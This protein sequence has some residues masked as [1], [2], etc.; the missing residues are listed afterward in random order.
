M[1]KICKINGFDGPYS[2][3]SNFHLCMVT[4]GG[5]TYA[6]VEHAYQAAKARNFEDHDYVAAAIKP[7]EAKRRGREIP[8]RDDWEKIKLDVMYELLK[9]KFS[10]PELR[11]KLLATQDA[12]LVENNW[13]GDRYWGECRGVGENHLGK[14]LMKVRD[15]ISRGD[16]L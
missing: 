15:G 6:S 7:K 8:L 16:G 14:L 9:A 10:E 2:F 3:L 4:Y 13:W 1:P 12:E 5:F 11:A